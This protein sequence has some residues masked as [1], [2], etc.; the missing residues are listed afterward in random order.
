MAMDTNA[1]KMKIK[2]NGGLSDIAGREASSRSRAAKAEKT[3]GSEGQ[4][5]T[6]P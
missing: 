1:K 3:E 4:A 5:A 2:M 6:A